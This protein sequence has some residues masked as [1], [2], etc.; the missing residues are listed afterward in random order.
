M[1][2]GE[3]A[4]QGTL[5][6]APSRAGLCLSQREQERRRGEVKSPT[7]SPTRGACRRRDRAVCRSPSPG[8]APSRRS[9]CQSAA[10]GVS[11]TSGRR[12]PAPHAACLPGG[13]FPAAGT[14]PR[15]LNLMLPLIGA[16]SRQA[17]WYLD[18][19]VAYNAL[20]RVE[21]RVRLA[22]HIRKEG[23]YSSSGIF[24]AI[25]P[26]LTSRPERRHRLAAR[27]AHSRN[28]V[29]WKR[30]SP[31][32]F[33]TP[34]RLNPPAHSTNPRPHAHAHG[35]IQWPACRLAATECHFLLLRRR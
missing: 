29:S 14:L 10:W 3:M 12:P 2:R 22:A 24:S 23:I 1:K 16:H 25:P 35:G 17:R 20:G 32:P 30:A 34:R 31:L 4:S 13:S 7:R 33:V 15:A 9:T 27:P 28:P 18:L 6:G 19:V 11:R 21:G 8:Q 5:P 26:I